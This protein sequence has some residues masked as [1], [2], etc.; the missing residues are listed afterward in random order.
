MIAARVGWQGDDNSA[1]CLVDDGRAGV[2]G[3]AVG[4]LPDGSGNGVGA[5]FQVQC[6][7]CFGTFGGM[8]RM[9]QRG[10][11]LQV[12]GARLGGEAGCC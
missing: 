4:T 2:V 8:K 12:R 10:T 5:W 9:P 1:G 7:V 3:V 11:N 6:P